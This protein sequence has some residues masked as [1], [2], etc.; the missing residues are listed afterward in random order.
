MVSM[1]QV[2]PLRRISFVLCQSPRA[3]T[4]TREEGDADVSTTIVSLYA[5]AR[6]ARIPSLCRWFASPVAGRWGGQRE[7][8]RGGGRRPLRAHPTSHRELEGQRQR[9]H[10]GSLDPPVVLVKHVCK[11]TILVLETPIVSD[12][13]G[14][15]LGGQRPAREHGGG[16]KGRGRRRAGQP[17]SDVCMRPHRHPVRSNTIGG[18]QGDDRLTVE[19]ERASGR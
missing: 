8:M 5:P 1:S 6:S 15:G 2:S 10:L 14:V 7:G 16:G 19:C 12:G 13:R 17:R 11:D 3:W 4:R 18:Q 9:T